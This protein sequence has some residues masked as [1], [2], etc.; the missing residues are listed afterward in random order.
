MLNKLGSISAD[1]V[2]ACL[3][4]SV[5][6]VLLYGSRWPRA[7]RLL[8]VYVIWNLLIEVGARILAADR[9]N[10]LPL[11]HLYTLGEFV[12]FS[13]FYRELF[14]PGHWFR[15]SVRLG[16]ARLEAF[17]PW[18]GG[19]SLLVIMNSL[20]L[21]SIWEFNSFAKTLV[22]LIL[23]GYAIAFMFRDG[24]EGGGPA[25]RRSATRWVNAAVLI[26]YSGSLFIFMFSNYF[27]SR[28]MR[29]HQGFWAFNA[30]LNLV[31]QVIIMLMLWSV[32]RHRKSIY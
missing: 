4:V 13:L 2:V 7:F 30:I 23:I 24:E 14:G 29:L 28:G 22:Q 1:L 3:V 25:G 10:N 9:L 8:G 16:R 26:Y 20:Y 6:L 19:I 5:F 15:R 18:L 32:S 17:A 27:L 11:L 31:F 12:L 21:Q